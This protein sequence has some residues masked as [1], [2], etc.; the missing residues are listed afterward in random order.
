MKKETLTM[1]AL[2]LIELNLINGH[3]KNFFRADACVTGAKFEVTCPIR[4]NINYRF[5]M[6]YQYH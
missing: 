4:R 6:E 5:Q 1:R 2:D 3:G